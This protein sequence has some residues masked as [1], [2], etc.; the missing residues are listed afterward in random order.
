VNGIFELRTA[1]VALGLEQRPERSVN[2]AKPGD[3]SAAPTE[4]Q[5]LLLRAGGQIAALASA[6]LV[7]F[8]SDLADSLRTEIASRLGCDTAAVALCATHTHGTPNP[9]ARFAYGEA[10]KSL[11]EHIRGRVL[12]GV[13][14]A[15]A[16]RPEEVEIAVGRALA[17]NIAV[18]RRRRAWTRRGIVPLRRTQS[19]PNHA[20]EIDERISVLSFRAADGRPKAL[21]SHFG[22]HPVADPATRRG[23]DYPG[24]L[25]EA[26][27]ARHGSGVVCAFLQGFCGDVRPHLVRTPAGLKDHLREA[28]I[29]PRFR[30]STVGDAERIAAALARAAEQ[31]ELAARSIKLTTFAFRRERL[32]L[33]DIDGEPTGRTLDVTLWRLGENLRL[34]FA[35]AEML[36]GLATAA[37]DTLHVGYANGMVG[38]IAP[39]E[40]YAGG[41]Y[42]IDGFLG[43]FG[44]GKRFAPEAA[45]S[46]RAL[47]L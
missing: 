19:L 34:V 25:R 23:A 39:P 35:S 31:A 42:E 8:G 1:S 15:L 17:P 22:C 27:K 38:Y 9:D 32:S 29:G 11:V 18:N 26:L 14:A 2:G 47:A 36:S 5:V 6:D 10:S 13:E 12:E 20:R 30:H 37:K 43:R 7:W 28:V 46:F 21:V 45:Q 40:Y 16:A 41:G 44:L 33:T 4:A 24:L 3:P